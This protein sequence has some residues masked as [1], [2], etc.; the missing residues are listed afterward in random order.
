MKLSKIGQFERTVKFKIPMG[1]G[2]YESQCVP[3]YRIMSQP[4]AD[5]LQEK[6]KKQFDTDEE[7][8]KAFLDEV[9]LGVKGIENEDGSQASPEEGRDAIKKYP[10]IMVELM[11]AFHDFLKDMRVKN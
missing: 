5:E 8:N 6:F 9:L 1:S 3:I 11:N 2:V 4:Q 10:I 7:R